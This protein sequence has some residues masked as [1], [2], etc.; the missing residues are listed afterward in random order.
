MA[1]NQKPTE[2]E[3]LKQKWQR[4][5]NKVANAEA[6]L[7]SQQE[8]FDILKREQRLRI[9]DLVE[10]TL[11]PRGISSESEVIPDFVTFDRADIAWV[12]EC[13]GSIYAEKTPEDCPVD[14]PF[15]RAVFDI[16]PHCLHNGEQGQWLAL[17]IFSGSHSVAETPE[18]AK[19]E[20]LIGKYD[21]PRL[22]G[23]ISPDVVQTKLAQDYYRWRYESLKKDH[24]WVGNFLPFEVSTDPK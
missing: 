2:F 9:H 15:M 24:L 23:V 10:A 12:Y 22:F 16:M 11:K 17:G 18:I 5:A 19:K 1:E 21:L 7:N 4:T 14:D 8:R 13:A 3:R 20:M 6:R